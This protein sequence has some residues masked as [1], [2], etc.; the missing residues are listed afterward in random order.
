M[1]KQSLLV[2]LLLFPLGWAVAQDESEADVVITEDIEQEV[3]EIDDDRRLIIRNRDGKNEL[4]E[5][6]D[7]DQRVIVVGEDTEVEVDNAEQRVIVRNGQNEQVIDLNTSDRRV[8]IIDDARGSRRE[9]VRS[10]RF[11]DRI[12]EFAESIGEWAGELGETIGESFSDFGGEREHY[13][14]AQFGNSREIDERRSMQPGGRIDIENIAGRVTVT[15]WNQDAIQLKGTIGEDVDEVRFRVNDDDARIE[16]DVPNGRN[17]KIRCDLIIMVPRNSSLNIET[18]SAP[19]EISGVEA[20]SHRIESVSGKIELSDTKGNVNI[21][22]VSGGVTIND[23]NSHAKIDT[24]SGSIKLDGLA[25]S[26]DAETVS[27]SVQILGV[28]EEVRVDAISGSVKIYGEN[29]EDINV[30]TVSGSV[31][32][33]GSLSSNT[34]VDIH[35]IS[36]SVT[37][38]ISGP[39]P[40]EYDLRTASG[41]INCSFGPTVERRR[42]PGQTLRFELDERD[43]DVRIETFSGSI[44]V[45]E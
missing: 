37:L 41:S 42:G 17:R 38:K 12:A 40:G 6:N 33:D 8:I 27:G 36:G 30:E 31:N 9:I 19:I 5:L 22:T 23:A 28:K 16:I 15:G 7:P 18:V 29:V 21:E 11:G 39:L 34:E 2:A 32:F 1:L 25:E 20:S 45:H 44:N 26:V 24:V 14:R 13:A 3:V 43:G 35:T 10:E 4:L